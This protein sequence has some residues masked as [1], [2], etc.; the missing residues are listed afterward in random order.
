[1]D[2]QSLRKRVLS[3]A[4]RPT[5]LVV[6]AVIDDAKVTHMR[7]VWYCWQDIGHGCGGHRK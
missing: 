5:F 7:S 6:L 4:Q 3:G 2:R 1:V